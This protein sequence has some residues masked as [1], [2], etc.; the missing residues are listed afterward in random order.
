MYEDIEGP[1]EI[2]GSAKWESK[3]FKYL[4]EFIEANWCY[5]L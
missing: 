1:V 4:Y 5:D 3:L 2:D